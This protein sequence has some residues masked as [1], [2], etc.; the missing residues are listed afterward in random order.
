MQYLEGL[1]TSVIPFLATKNYIMTKEK[2]VIVTFGIVIV[3]AGIIAALYIHKKNKA[4]AAT[5]VL[6]PATKQ[7]PVIKTAAVQSLPPVLTTT[8]ISDLQRLQNQAANN[9]NNAAIIS[10]VAGLAGS[11]IGGIDFGGGTDVNANQFGG[12]DA[13]DTGSID[14]VDTGNIDTSSIDTL[15]EIT[16]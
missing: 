2:E 12:V 11:I 9:N 15:A 3:V 10:G 8:Q 13:F 16:A 14:A 6:K 5:P 4:K 7:K 1:Q